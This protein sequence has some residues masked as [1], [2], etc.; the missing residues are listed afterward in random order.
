MFSSETKKSLKHALRSA[1]T[2]V[3]LLGTVGTT[4]ALLNFLTSLLTL[5]LSASFEAMLSAYKLLIH[6]AI[7][8]L[9]FF[10]GVKL[11]LWAK[12]MIF[13]Y[14]IIGGAFM[15]SRMRETV[16]AVPPKNASL[17]KSLRIVCAPVVQRSDGTISSLGR[18]IDFYQESPF[19]VRR[20]MDILLWPRI[21]KRYFAK[22]RVFFNPNSGT[23]P[24]FSMHS[25]PGPYLV[26]VYDR[27]HIFYMQ[28]FAAI[29]ATL[30]A[31][32]IGGF[33]ELPN[34]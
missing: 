9:L 3:S 29:A 21:A 26:F 34:T 16:K 17:L 30:F 7:D 28:L 31:L 2:L 12:D 24:A 11:P 8:W 1:V 20:I 4:I 33:S 15:R 10:V 13:I 23:H 5:S 18:M 25:D 32:V 14:L 6:G 22:P 19:W 27:R